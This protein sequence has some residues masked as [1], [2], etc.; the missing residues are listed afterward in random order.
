MKG[1]ELKMGEIISQDVSGRLKRSLGHYTDLTS[2]T[3][4]LADKAKQ[5]WVD[6]TQA[7]YNVKGD[8]TDETTAMQS[9]LD[10][11]S[12]NKRVLYVPS[13]ITVSVSNLVVTGKS[14][15]G[16]RV[17]GTIKF[18]NSA[19]ASSTILKLDTCNDVNIYNFN[20]DG[21]VANNGVTINEQLHLIRLL[22][23]NRIFVGTIV[24]KNPTGD[25]VYINNCTDV[26]ADKIYGFGSNVGRNTISIVKGSRME[27]SSVV[28]IGVGTDTMPSGIDL[29]PNSVTDAI[30]Y[31]QFGKVYVESLGTSSFSLYNNFGADCRN[32]TVADLVVNKTTPNAFKNALYIYKFNNVKIKAVLRENQ[33]TIANLKTVALNVDGGDNINLDVDISNVYQGASIGLTTNITNLKLSGKIYSVLY[34]GVNVTKLSNSNLRDLK[35]YQ[36]DLANS[37]SAWNFRFTSSAV[38]SNVNFKNCDFSKGTSGYRAV[39]VNGTTTNVW[40]E[41]CDFS[42]WATINEMFSGNYTTGVF[43]KNNKAL[44][45]LSTPPTSYYWNVGEIIWNNAPSGATPTTYWL[46]VTNGTGFAVGTD[47]IAK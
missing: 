46:R 38:V 37:G 35:V 42:G 23:C 44:N 17:D 13:Y 41:D 33:S 3:S 45:Y 36:G 10:Y 1:S 43:R 30:S 25:V 26:I 29:E 28:S 6:V 24:G 27:F 34:E 4:Q 14:N 32:I 20:G 16:I 39:N 40:F 7:P 19:P 22:N 31:I 12:N 5:H 15:F 8:G 18:I 47:W 11:A 21:N 9:A 2:L